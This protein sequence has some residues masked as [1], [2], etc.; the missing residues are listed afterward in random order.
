[1]ARPRKPTALRV[2]T[3]GRTRPHHSHAAAKP[4]PASRA[5]APPPWLQGPALAAWNSVVGELVA[6]GCVTRLDGPL[7]AAWA[8]ATGRA[9]E[10]EL[11][12]NEL[13]GRD[14]LLV[15]TAGRK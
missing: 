4:N 2:V 13:G 3:G 11:M 14:R 10:A 8:S 1:M 15:G 9:V 7:L 12:L 5:P 6:L